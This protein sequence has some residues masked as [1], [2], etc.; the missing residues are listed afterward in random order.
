MIGRPHFAMLNISRYIMSRSRKKNPIFTYASCKSQK[1][2]KRQCNK[3]F[4]RI[5]RHRLPEDTELPIH[6]KEV[7]DVWTMEGDGKYRLSF[8]NPQYIKAIRK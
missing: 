2:S 3:R 8:D 6:T 5:V 4:R 7:M 1:K